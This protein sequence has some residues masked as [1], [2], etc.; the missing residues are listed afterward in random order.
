MAENKYPRPLKI[1]ALFDIWAFCDLINY[2]GGR[3]NFSACHRKLAGFITSTQ[4]SNPVKKGKRYTKR[5]MAQMPRGHL[6]STIGSVLYLLWRIYRNPDI[7]VLYGSAELRLTKSFIREL[8]QYLENEEL[9]EN[10]WNS[11]PHIDGRLIP[12][13][14]GMK[15]RARQRGEEFEETEATDKKVMWNVLSI[16][17]VRKWMGK[18][19]TVLATSLGSKATGDHYD[20]LILDDVVDKFNSD[21]EGKRENLFEWC[22]DLESVIDPSRRMLVGKVGSIEVWDEVGDE[23]LILGTRYFRN[24]YYEYIEKNAKDLEYVVFKRN[25]YVNGVNS[26]NGFLWS[27][28]FN[29]ETVNRLRKRLTTKQWASQ[30][31]NKIFDADTTSLNREKIKYYASR[32][33]HAAS[34]GVV[35]I[36][37]TGFPKPVQLRPYIIIDPAISQKSTADST[38]ITVGAVDNNGNVYIIDVKYGKFTPDKT[39]ELV[40]EVVKKWNKNAVYLETN[41]VGA[42]LTYTLKN[43]FKKTKPIIVYEHR[44]GQGNVY[45]IKGDKTTR[46]ENRIQ[47]LLE[48]GQIYLP[49]WLASKQEVMDEFD[50]FPSKSG[51]DDF[52]DTIDQLCSIAKPTVHK[53][54]QHSSKLHINSRYGGTR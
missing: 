25:I 28:K 45:G 43:H 44:V 30:Y 51:H 32:D 41:N 50:L 35:S 46:I 20:L 6:K 11:R 12:V 5:R 27:E 17:V 23:V 16:Q 26:D 7:R 53:K 22:Q 3:K 52:L 29:A 38:C 39:V 18:E 54:V 49:D 37:I 47:P 36:K 40:E 8:K 4:C 15:G 10:V 19:P 34:E 42:A 13:L 24:D 48:N 2:R 14:D 33:V 9:S 1:K 21:T 31:L